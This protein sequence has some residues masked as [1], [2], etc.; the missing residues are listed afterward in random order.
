MQIKT[1][2][3]VLICQYVLRLVCTLHVD[4]YLPW[5]SIDTQSLMVSVTYSLVQI[6]KYKKNFIDPKQSALGWFDQNLIQL[7][8]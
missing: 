7:T 2:P 8:A 6:C 1:D 4:G 5:T 3:M